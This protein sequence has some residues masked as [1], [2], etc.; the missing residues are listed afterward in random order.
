MVLVVRQDRIGFITMCRDTRIEK[1]WP[2][3]GMINSLLL[4]KGKM[5]VYEGG[6]CKLEESVE[7]VNGQC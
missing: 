3:G 1:L 2:I 6:K 4:P 7:L 5:Y